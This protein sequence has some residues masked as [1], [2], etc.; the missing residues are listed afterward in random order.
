MGRDVLA[1]W[2]CA[3]GSRSPGFAKG[4]PVDGNA[5]DGSVAAQNLCGAGLEDG[6]E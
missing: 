2:I 4:L 6:P 1:A 3:V 5:E